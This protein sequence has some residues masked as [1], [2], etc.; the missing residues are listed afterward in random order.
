MELI[1]IL[2]IAVSLAMDAFAASIA[3]GVREV[4]PTVTKI[5]SIGLLFGGFQAVMPV[6]G[7]LLGYSL[8][9]LI[10]PIDHWIA[11]ALLAGI[12]IHMIAE[13]VKARKEAVECR[14]FGKKELLF[15][16]VATS[17]DAFA[18]GTSLAVLDIGILIPAAIIGIVTLI[19]SSAGIYLGDRI[20]TRVGWKVE[21]I[22]GIVLVII[23]LRI[24]I[25]HLFFG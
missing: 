15:L 16:A 6:I 11:F 25:E 17:I 10:E 24:L 2:I 14:P 12:G 23:G 18:V 5:I 7:W 20:S 9:D 3:C 1:T 22:G 4:K 21:I 19:L 8:R 13:S